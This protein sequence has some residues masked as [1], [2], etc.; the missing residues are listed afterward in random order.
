MGFSME[1][2]MI[3][4]GVATVALVSQ[5]VCVAPAVAGS[6]GLDALFVDWIGQDRPGCAVTVTRDGR[7]LAARAYGQAI[8]EAGKPN[9]TVTEFHVASVSKQFTAM[10][11]RLLEAEGRITLQDDVRTHV[12]ELQDFGST[13]TIAHLLNH[14]SG[15]RDQWELLTIQG[16]R[17][18]DAFSQEDVLRVLAAQR[19]LNFAPGDRHSY[20][21]S[22]YT[23]LATIVERVSGQPFADFMSQRV[24]GPLGMVGSYINADVRTIRPAQAWPYASG[25]SG[26]ERRQL[27]YSNY[28][29][30][31]LRTT[32]DDMGR[33]LIHL[34]AQAQRPEPADSATRSTID[35]SGREVRYAWGLMHGEHRG[36]QILEH[37]GIDPGFAAQLIVVPRRR[38]GVAVMCNVETDRAREIARQVV[39]LHL[40]PPGAPPA[41]SGEAPV[42]DETQLGEF[43]GLYLD[44]DGLPFSIELRDGRLV[45]QGH[46]ELRPVAPN[47][48]ELA[49]APV[50]LR[51]DEDGTLTI[52]EAGQERRALRHDGDTPPLLAGRELA[53][54]AGDYY[55]D[56]LGLVMRVEPVRDELRFR[57][58]GIEAPLFQP[59]DALRI[60]D[61][62]F[63]PSPMGWIRFNR[64]SDGEIQSLSATNGRV[65]NLRF[66]RLR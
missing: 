59:P 47:Q 6:D 63:S 24:F 52:R 30:T 43:A 46:N 53:D 42:L 16:R 3:R 23:L 51:F 62:F 29:A 58:P 44:E 7:V 18:G 33:W 61:M 37:S 55:S 2:L 5:L 56:E 1:N 38:L 41:P 19:E 45:A 32:A 26:Y 28:G 49:S 14:T 9:T 4:L 66:S 31:D 21:N 40:G 39:D 20:S 36:E 65:V 64:D 12:P 54:Y 60:R 57:S 34:E 25:P 17:H 22:N 50:S 35:A 48:F 10:A 15:L 27:A 11:I 13:I 8:V